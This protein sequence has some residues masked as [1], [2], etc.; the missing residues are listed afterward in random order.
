MARTM[1]K[2][3]PEIEIQNKLLEKTCAE[4]LRAA[5]LIETFDG[6]IYTAARESSEAWTRISGTI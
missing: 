1:T 5:R 4:F 6:N 3:K 2:A